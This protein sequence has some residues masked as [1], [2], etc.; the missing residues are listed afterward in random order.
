MLLLNRLLPGEKQKCKIFVWWLVPIFSKKRI[1]DRSKKKK[2]NYKTTN[3]K[4]LFLE[5]VSVG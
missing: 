5:N 4:A 1:N 2:I 3:E